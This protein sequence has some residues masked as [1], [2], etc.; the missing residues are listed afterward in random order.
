[1]I[2]TRHKKGFTALW[3][4]YLLIAF[5]IVYMISPFGIYYYSVYGKGLLFLSNIPVAS[6]LTGFFLPHFAQTSS[7][8][9]NTYKNLGWILAIGGFLGFCIGAGQVYFAK[10]TRK[11]AVTRG[12]Y[13]FIRHPQY[14]SLSICSF[15]LLLV[16]PRYL[17]LILFIS[18]LFAYYFLARAEE[19]ECEEKFGK[20]Y[21]AY[22]N[23][24]AMF[25]PLPMKL[26]VILPQRGMKRF[27]AVLA[28]YLVVVTSSVYAANLLKFF[29]ISHLYAAY[30]ENSAVLS[31]A[32]MDND[33]MRTIMEIA[34]RDDDVQSRLN[35]TKAGRK[36]KFLNYVLPAEWFFPDIPMNDDQAIGEHYAPRDYDRNRY[37]ILFMRAVLQ[38]QAGRVEGK[39]LLISSLKREPIIEVEVSLNENKVIRIDNPPATVI[40][41]D[42]PTPLF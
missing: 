25:L 24:T 18:M 37:K 42:I 32:K 35:G 9:L 2:E 40:W 13:S 39:G 38:P 30:S 31:L 6:R 4:F 8:M 29:S 26:P 12:I 22:K 23:R 41:G 21:I 33:R 27:I 5:E 7:F 11:P 1:M 3:I 14:V 10:F 34:L 17:V 36:Q 19:K 16:W 28:L 20:P 15:G